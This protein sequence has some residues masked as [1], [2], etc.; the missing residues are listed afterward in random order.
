[1]QSRF[2]ARWE[3]DDIPSLAGRVAVVTGAAS[4]IGLQVARRLGERGAHV[5]LADCDVAG[6]GIAI[7]QLEHH[8]PTGGYRGLS[9]DLSSFESIRDAASDLNGALGRLDILVNNAGIMAPPYSETAQGFELQFGVNYRGHYLMTALLWRLLC[10]TPD[11]RVVTVSSAFAYVA[12]MNWHDPN[13][14]ASR[15]SYRPFRA[16]AQSKLAT[17][18]FA[19]D[20][21]CRFRE[22]G[23]GGK[24]LAAHP[25]IANTHLHITTAQRCGSRL[26]GALMACAMKLCGQSAEAGARSILRAATDESA[27]GGALYGPSRMGLWGPPVQVRIPA[28]G[29]DAGAARRLMDV[30]EELTGVGFPTSVGLPGS[31]G[32]S[33]PPAGAP[34]RTAPG[35]IHRFRAKRKRI[36]LTTREIPLPTIPTISAIFTNR[37]SGSAGTPEKS[38]G[39]TLYVTR[40]ALNEKPA[41]R[42]WRAWCRYR[43]E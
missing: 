21:D 8:A 19:L 6:T 36:P 39:K 33:A 2:D 38:K 12:R 34:H 4:G 29:A 30:S 1:M 20:L 42:A 17:L 7:R 27:P 13:F 40:A 3:L 11:S 37:S 16:Y 5:V 10:T 32:S 14:R 22:A 35:L 15:P 23:S 25:G 26:Q 41:M 43:G 24:S 31:A 9:V 28:R 18:L